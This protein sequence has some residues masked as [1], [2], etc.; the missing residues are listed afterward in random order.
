MN[1]NPPKTSTMRVLI[2]ANVF[3]SYLLPAK[4]SE[5]SESVDTIIDAGFAGKYTIFFPQELLSEIKKK[6]AEKP[7]LVKYI[8]QEDGEEFVSLITGI[9][10]LLPPITEEIP[11]VTRD[12][13][14]DYLLAYGLVGECEYLVSGDPYLLELQQVEGFKIITPRKFFE[15]LKN[16]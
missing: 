7:Y 4:N 2:D 5:K 12:K 11:E 9:A 1:V 3:I 13:K 16:I 10:E 15:I 6:L 8:S 14:D